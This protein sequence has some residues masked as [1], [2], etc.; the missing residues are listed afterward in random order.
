MVP[1]HGGPTDF[2]TI[3][4]ATALADS[5]GRA[6][7]TLV[8]VVEV[9]Q[10]F[11]L[12]ADLPDQIQ[13]GEAVIERAERYAQQR[14]GTVWRHVTATLLQARLAAAAVVDEAIERGA[15]AIVLGTTNQRRFG[16][17]TQGETVPYILDNAPCDVVVLRVMGENGE[18]A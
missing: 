14:T 3:D 2:R 17:L 10:Q 5:G 7:L 9:P 11:A 15:D 12:D 6:D 8:Y 13:A 16:V 1:V 18:T 4:G